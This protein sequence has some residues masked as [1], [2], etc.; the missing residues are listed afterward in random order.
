MIRQF[1][2]PVLNSTADPS[3]FHLI[4][5]YYNCLLAAELTHQTY[6]LKSVEDSQGKRGLLKPPSP[7]R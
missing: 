6:K 3:L 1:F 7:P 2:T 4:T 5:Q